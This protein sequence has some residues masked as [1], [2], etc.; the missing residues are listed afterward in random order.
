MTL[1]FNKSFESITVEDLQLLID[2]EVSERQN[3]EYKSQRY[4]R[5]DED[6][7]EMLRDISS[8]ANSYGGYI[9]L[10]IKEKDDNS[11]LPVKFVGI[12]EG[13]NERNRIFSSCLVNIEPRLSGLQVKAIDL[14]GEKSVLVIF[15]PHSTRAPHIITFK[16]LNQFWIRHDRQKSKMSVEEIRDAFLKTENILQDIRNFLQK[17]R[18]EILE[19]INHHPYYIIGASPLLIKED[20][21]DIFDQ[22]VRDLL[23]NP[24]AQRAEGWNLD[25]DIGTEPHPT[26]WGLKIEIKGFR[27]VELF[28]NG[29]LEAAINIEESSFVKEQAKISGKNHPVLYPYPLVEYPVSFFRLLKSLREYLGLEGPFITFVSLLNIP[30]FGLRRWRPGAI[31]Y[32][33]D[34]EI[35]GKQHLEIPSS[36]IMTLSDPDNTAKFFV[37]RIWQAFG[38]EK[39]PLF[40]EGKFDPKS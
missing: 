1:I 2:R 17:R 29:Y 4:A 38:Y 5:S 30:G 33:R 12:D 14:D 31:T 15:V 40:K 11:G 28:R 24:P 9:F 21:I 18:T 16:G 26:L 25:F 23:K 39:A 19:E 35:W 10:G 8:M 20:I 22:Q 6:V 7:R 13:E 37:D 3:L 27:S 32:S 36:Q 34:L